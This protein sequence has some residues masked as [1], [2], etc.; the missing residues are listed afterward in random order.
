MT[1]QRRSAEA[2]TSSIGLSGLSRTSG[3]TVTPAAAAGGP[4]RVLHF[5][6]SKGLYGP[7]RWTHLVL[8]SLT[9]ADV[10]LE[11]LTIGTKPGYDDFARFL[12]DAGFPA[13]H[14][15]IGGKIGREAVRTIRRFLVEHRIDVLHTHGFKS[16]ILG[17][18]ATRG[19]PVG[20]VT[21]PHGW[22]DHESLRIHAY[23]VVGRWALHGFDRVYPVSEHQIAVLRRYGLR[24]AVRLIRNAVD[25][26]GFDEVHRERMAEP[27]KSRRVLFVGRLCR[28]KGAI[29]LVR[30][31]AR[32]D[33]EAM[34][35][36]VGE[37]PAD[38]DAREL[39]EAL[40]VASRVRFA[41]FQ[42]DVR[43][44]LRDAAVLALP[45]YSEGIPRVVMEAFAAG[46]PVVGTDIP[47]LRE[48]VTDG[49]NGR[50]VPV[51]D[52]PG[53][54]A[55][56]DAIL[57][58]PTVGTQFAIRARDVLE[59]LYSPERLCAELREEYQRV[60]PKKASRIA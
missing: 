38:A 36:I 40:G 37:G 32:L 13:F 27:R 53:L 56:L 6:S 25:I 18:L 22:C 51:G 57:V 47:G 34:L 21:T 52:P 42:K 33:R 46:V 10:A 2:A 20:L 59:R 4:I 1:I 5:H 24:N 29:D 48:L 14:L 49:D 17:Y 19:L 55:A 9:A 16:D 39:A 28:E 26:A 44:F 23:E 58:N 50:L 45:S 8:R 41:G 31:F 7:E 43:P 15:P 54:A 60:A 11:V 35:D 12:R 3:S 30:A